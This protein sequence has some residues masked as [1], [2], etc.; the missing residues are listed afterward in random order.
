MSTVTKLAL[1]CLTL[2]VLQLT[3]KAIAITLLV[4]L[5]WCVIVRPKVVLAMLA[6][7][8][9]IHFAQLHTVWFIAIAVGLF[10]LSRF[11]KGGSQTPP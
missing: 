2:A 9:T 7:G 11:D 4:A 6:L 1:L 10:L 5:I 8:A 3:I